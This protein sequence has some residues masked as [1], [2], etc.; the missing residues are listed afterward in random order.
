MTLAE[1]QTAR[2]AVYDAYVAALG[3]PKSYTKSSAG[4]SSLSVQAQDIE[5]L[6]QQLDNL[7]TD[8]ALAGGTVSR[9]VYIRSQDG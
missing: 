8:I 5:V 1:L 7:D 6:K 4:G 2:A 9:T 3:K